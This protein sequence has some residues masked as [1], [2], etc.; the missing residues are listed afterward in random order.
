MAIIDR[1]VLPVGRLVMGNV[2]EGNDKDSEGQPLVDSKGQP[3][4]K[5]FMAFAIKKTPGRTWQQEEWGAKIYAAGKVAD[6]VRHTTDKFS[7]KVDDGDSLVPNSKGR[8]NCDTE[9]FPGHWIVKCDGYYAPK[10]CQFENGI[11]VPLTRTINLGDY[12]QAVVAIDSNG[13]KDH[14]AGIKVYPEAVGFV[15]EG[16]RINRAAD[17][18]SL[19]FGQGVAQ[20]QAATP[21]PT[22]T[23]GFTPTPT[24]TPPQVPVVPQ[25]QFL[26]AKTTA[27]KPAMTAKANGATY[28]QFK[29]AGWTDQQLL[30]Q[31]YIEIP[32]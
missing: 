28:E 16:Q 13:R 4:R 10:L 3:Y 1:V 31:D 24:V 6:P 23:G 11:T 17:F 26:V 12:A 9:G 27:F 8:R 2:H 22:P 32:F 14:N 18:T 25:P 20:F 5:F 30:E 29:A 19:G 21:K 7:W 15:Q